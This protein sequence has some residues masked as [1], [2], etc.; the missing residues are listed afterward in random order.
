MIGFT[1]LVFLS[2]SEKDDFSLYFDYAEPNDCKGQLVRD[3]TTGAEM[4]I[5]TFF[6]LLPRLYKDCSEHMVG[7]GEVL[8]VVV[9][10]L[11]PSNL[12]ELVC[13]LTMQEFSVFGQNN[14][15]QVSNCELMRLSLDSRGTV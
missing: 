10:S 2:E 3:L 9:A 14:A 1:F 15:E 4:A 13:G 5:D 12:H 7:N 6:K 8:K 11:D